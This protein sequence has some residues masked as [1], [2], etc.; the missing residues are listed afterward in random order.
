MI[1]IKSTGKEFNGQLEI[2]L[3]DDPYKGVTFYYESMKFADEENEDGLLNMSF[4]YQITSNNAPKRLKDFEKY[5]G[6]LIIQILEEQMKKN[7]VIYKGGEG[8][9]YDTKD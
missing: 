3:L 8:G 6:D 4:E 1:N 2:E 9:Q 7:E 5:I